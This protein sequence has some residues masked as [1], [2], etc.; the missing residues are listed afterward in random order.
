LKIER[1]TK[2][3]IRLL[4]MGEAATGKTGALAQL[5]NA[6][7][8]LMIHDF[9]QN[10]RVIADH[11]KEG[12]APVYVQT[13]D[14]A[15]LTNNGM[16]DTGKAVE[17]QAVKELN[18]FAAQLK[19]WNM[20][21]D[22]LGTWDTWTPKDVVVI[23][24]T[25]FMSRML[26]LAA[27][28]HPKANA[29]EKTHYKFA[30]EFQTKLLTDLTSKNNGAS[31]IVISHL[32]QTGDRDTDGNII[33]NVRNIPT[34]IGVAESKSMPTYFTDIWEIQINATGKREIKTAA[35]SKTALRASSPSINPVEPYDL[36]SMFNRL[37]GAPT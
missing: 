21:G 32:K 12:H 29:N 18:R 28:Q 27:P 4:L 6:G 24:S 25:T 23:D 15:R 3:P 1:G 31:V 9:D 14:V 8:R 33:G 19:H 20:D 5:A 36:A 11:L 30:G 7:Y 13:Y 17:Q 26:M 22:D 10:E 37:L 34:G 35:T 16:L 2:G